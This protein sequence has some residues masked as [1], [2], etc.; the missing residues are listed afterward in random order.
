MS[1]NYRAIEE[2]VD[3]ARGI[4]HHEI[5]PPV[6][7]A[8]QWPI[9]CGSR[10]SVFI[11][12]MYDGRGG[13]QQVAVK[14][15]HGINADFWTVQ[16][17][18]NREI[19]VWRYL[20]HPNVARFLGLTRN[21]N[22]PIPGIVLPLVPHDLMAYTSPSLDLKL[23]LLREI[24]A[25]VKYLHSKYVIHGDLKPDNVRVSSTGTA[26]ILDFGMGKIVGVHGFT[27]VLSANPRYMAPEFF[28]GEGDDDDA[29]VRPTFKSDIYSFA[30]LMLQVLHGTDLTPHGD[31]NSLPFNHIPPMSTTSLYTALP[32][33]K[34]PRRSRYRNITSAQW[35]LL[36]HCW[37]QDP[38]SRPSINEVITKI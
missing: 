38:R 4:I 25:G 17:R 23:R 30:M 20:D 7:K 29:P 6:Q 26:Q 8:G 21:F 32:K 3:I 22:G 2:C 28:S 34:R 5:S 31:D 24:A 9:G 27:T 37:H 35:S 15:I 10:G 16:K 11:G 12:H 1:R 18:V 19:A 36:E 14:I 13:Y 33:G